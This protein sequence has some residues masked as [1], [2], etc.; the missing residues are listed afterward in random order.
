MS[1]VPVNEAVIYLRL[2]SF[3]YQVYEQELFYTTYDFIGALG[4]ALGVFIGLHFLIFVQ[5][6][7]AVFVRVVDICVNKKWSKIHPMPE[8]AIVEMALEE[9]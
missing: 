3:T 4:G 5:F 8:E 6:F 1:D 9:L 2:K 7:Y